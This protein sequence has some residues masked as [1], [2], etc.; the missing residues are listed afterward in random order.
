LVSSRVFYRKLFDWYYGPTRYLEPGLLRCLADN[1]SALVLSNLQ[2]RSVQ[3]YLIAARRLGI[4]IVGNIASWDHPVGKGVVF[5]GCVKYTVQNLYMRDVLRDYHGIDETRIAITGWPQTDLYA[6]QRPREEYRDLL[7]SYRLDPDKPCILLTGNTENNNPREPQFVGRVLDRWPTGPG[8]GRPNIIF[9][10]HP[11]DSN[12]RKRFSP[13]ANRSGFHLQSASYTDTD[14]LALLLQHVECVVTNAGTILLDSLVNNRP[15]VCVLYD[16]AGTGEDALAEKNVTGHH[17]VDVMKS[18]SFI[19]ARSFEGVL[20]GIHRCLANP[21]ELAPQRHAIAHR[22]VGEM[23]GRAGE[24]LVGEIL[25][26][27]T[28]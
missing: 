27:L 28:K 7:R 9:R 14:V 10:P 25:V 17:Y 15:V 23:D 4:P 24:R 8:V 1:V 12:W 26:S 11:K 21:G 18:G 22:T 13:L 6:R 16:E 5:P 3:P 20:D 2:F 19:E